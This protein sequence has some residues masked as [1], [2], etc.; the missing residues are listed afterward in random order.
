M[1]V[2]NLNTKKSH[3][4]KGDTVLVISGDDAG[5]KG[6][7]MKVMPKEG[8]IL[9]E[10]I[11]KCVKHIK[12]RKAGQHGGIIT[13]ESPIHSSKV[14]VVCDKCGKATRA[15]RRILEDGT[16]IRACK[17]CGEALNA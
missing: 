17:H 11:N 5:K 3:I 6:K 16:K 14:M 7:V 8:R 2:K 9:V 10:G 4:R 15:S 1:E 13:Q 12:P